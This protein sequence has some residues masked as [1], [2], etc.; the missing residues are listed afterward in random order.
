MIDSITF[1]IRIGTFQKLGHR[2]GKN[3][4]KTD[5][6]YSPCYSNTFTDLDDSHGYFY[7]LTFVFSYVFL[8]FLMVLFGVYIDT[9]GS[10][11]IL[12]NYSVFFL[13]EDR[14]PINFNFLSLPC[15]SNIRISVLLLCRIIFSNRQAILRR[16][17]R[18]KKRSIRFLN[19]INLFFIFP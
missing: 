3:S 1:R 2:V 11:D 7:C 8:T 18:C 4:S 16:S 5:N 13:K 12:K 9:I 10:K 6:S 17:L 19:Y 14:N 15:I